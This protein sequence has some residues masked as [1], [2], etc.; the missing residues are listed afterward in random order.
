MLEATFG[1][2][3]SCLPSLRAL[4]KSKSIDSV[5]KSWRSILSV[6][7]SSASKASSQH[8]LALDTVGKSE[9]SMEADPYV[10]SYSPAT[11][12][13]PVTHVIGPGRETHDRL[14]HLPSGRIVVENSI[15]SETARRSPNMV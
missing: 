6:H 3:A 13:S 9:G 14:G 12:N 8:D 4:V 11:K 5:F 1:L 7:S 10:I 2:L 15:E